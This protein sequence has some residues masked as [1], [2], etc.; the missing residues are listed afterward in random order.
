MVELSDDSSLG[1]IG[2][3][4][5]DFSQRGLTASNRPST[6]LEA[7]FK[8]QSKPSIPLPHH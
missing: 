1:E 8:Q 2:N 6:Y 7:G 5:Y 3:D 4:Y